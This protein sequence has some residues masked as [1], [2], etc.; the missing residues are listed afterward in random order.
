MASGANDFIPALRFRAL[1]RFYDM[2]L[3]AAAAAR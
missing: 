1:T 3:R 2:V